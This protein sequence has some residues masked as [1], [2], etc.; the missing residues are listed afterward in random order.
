MAVQ[1]IEN[2]LKTHQELLDRNRRRVEA[3]ATGGRLR[4]EDV[5]AQNEEDLADLTQRL[6]HT[7]AARA[8][9]L[10]RYDTEIR[11]LQDAI[12]RLKEDGKR[13]DEVLGGKTK[14]NAKPKAK[15]SGA[16]KERV[17]RKK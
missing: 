13:I 7:T 4:P 8:Q 16:K 1:T 14:P 10:S 5:R 2:L 12:A 17:G 6:E 9:A 15:A 3:V 11:R